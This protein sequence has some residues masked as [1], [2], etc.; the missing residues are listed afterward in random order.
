MA[1]EVNSEL[2]MSVIDRVE[3]VETEE[4]ANKEDKKAI[5]EDAKE[6]GLDPKY[7]KKIVALR[8]QDQEKRREED[9]M[10]ELYKAAAG[11]D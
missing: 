10:F 7:I 4:Q 8:K 11:I 2:L 9:A 3:R 6:K 1:D 5:Y